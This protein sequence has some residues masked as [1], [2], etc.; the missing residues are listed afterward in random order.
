[1]KNLYF[2]LVFFL[3]LQVQAQVD[4]FY[5]LP[6][7]VK[8]DANVPTPKEF[9]G[10]EVGEWHVS[11]DRLMYYMYKLAETSDRVTIEAHGN[12]YE[13]RPIL[14][15]TITSP[16][17][18]ENLAQIQQEHL[19]LCD[20]ERSDELDIENMPAILWMGY[21]IHGN[22][23]SGGNAS[24]AVAYYL[25]AA[26][27][28]KIERQ[29][30][31]TVILFDPAYNPD[32]FHRFSTWVNMHRGINE[33]MSD[34]NDREHREAWPGGRTNH[35]WFDL[36]R[37]WLP[38]QHPE[39]RA[40]VEKFHQWKPNWLTDHHEMGTN[41]TFFFQP[42]VPS[43]THP[44]TPS[45]VTA[46][47]ERV[48]EYH[49]RALDK[50]GSLY[51]TKERYDDFF[52]GK[53]STYPD[54]NGSVG[55]LF[56]QASSR[57]HQQESVNGILTFPFAIRNQVV[58]SFSTLDGVND[59]RK[60]LLNYQRDFFKSALQEA[61]QDKVKAYIFGSVKDPVRAYHLAK[62]IHQ[63]DISIYHP[64]KELVIDGVN[65]GTESSYIVPLKQRQYRLIK[66]MFEKRTTF[67][68]SLFYDI[69]AW[70]FPLAFNLYYSELSATTFR[71]NILGDKIEE[72]NFPTQAVTGGKSE[73]AYAFRWHGYYSPKALYQIQA[74]DLRTKVA[75][76]PFEADG[77]F[78]DYGS[79]V[80]PVEGQQLSSEEIYELMKQ[81]ANENGIKVF[82]LKGGLNAEG[83]DLGSNSLE[84]L[85]R[86]RVALLVGDGVSAYDAGEVWHLL[87]QRI[88]MPL[89]K[90]ELGNFRRLKLDKY[91]T[92]LMV[93]GN[94]NGLTDRDI[95]RLKRW[96]NQG[97][98]IVACKSALRWLSNKGFGKLD[99][100]S[101]FR[102]GKSQRD[103]FLPFAN[104]SNLLGA[105]VTGGAIFKAKGDLSH[106]LLYGY[107]RPEL[108]LFR[109]HNIFV[110][111][112]KDLYDTPILYEENPLASGYISNENEER[113]AG[114]AAA[115]VKQ[116][117]S[118]RIIMLVDNPNFRAFWYGTNKLFMNGIF[119]GGKM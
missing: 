1:M 50:I 10:F 9:L 41:S 22:E 82:G 117:G 6:S 69:S 89:S 116:M 55:I 20:P 84:T 110:E 25:A 67:A 91:N 19:Q 43:R 108:S 101:P 93:N 104:R 88:R 71:Q 103:V 12:T 48:G 79:I 83:P 94:Y 35:Y 54:V 70:T 21:S 16:E 99:F 37:D 65:Y 29:L 64:A 42:G 60:E 57:G 74:K 111:P 73:Y 46:F 115:S 66:S 113:L 34:P 5:Y 63:H 49:A 51:F 36:N 114:T 4:L 72:L 53:G 109:N 100:K 77:H 59:L 81:I 18:H 62:I 7:D 2:L 3:S 30:Q 56:E 58:T 28:D 102:Q 27:G 26:Q 39:S 52:Y 90:V 40:R 96:V 13:G 32:G 8:Y 15:L 61:D 87:D 92:I 33:V 11:H 118:G 98:N 78:F 17:N 31:E 44:L 80:V 45:K 105:Q 112:G 106:P 76:D 38:L 75:K 14:K 97:G 85:D 24:L 86:P 47:S 23:A 107:E 68:D 119:F 95:E